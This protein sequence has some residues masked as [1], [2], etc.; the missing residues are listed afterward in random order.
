[1]KFLLPF[2]LLAAA[3]FA[4][5]CVHEEVTLGARHPAVAL[6]ADGAVSF[7]G[8]QVPLEQL[9]R[10]LR[11]AGVET[12]DE[13]AI[14]VPANLSDPQVIRRVMGILARA[15]YT[16]PICVT[17]RHAAAY[18]KDGKNPM[19]EFE[20]DASSYPPGEKVYGAGW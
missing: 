8:E 12:T 17:D 16:R 2:T 18:Q 10:A 7:R 5:G 4:T 3:A 6:T 14:H 15:G 11:R 13:I 1:M 9:P 19:R 20:H